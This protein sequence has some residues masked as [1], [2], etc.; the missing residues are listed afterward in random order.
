[1]KPPIH[2]RKQIPFYY[3]KT[4]AEFQKDPYERYDD[5]VIRQ[6][7]LHLA[8]ELWGGY[9]MQGIL[10][11][12]AAY[13]KVEVSASILELGCGVGRWIA[14][15]AKE[16]PTAQCWG[17]DYSYQMLK[18]AY[19]YWIGGEE[20]MLDVSNK[21]FPH[22]VQIKGEQL[23]NLQFGLAKAESL[24]FD[25]N[26]QDLVFNSFLLDRLIDPVLGLKEMHRV[27]KPGGHLIVITPLNFSQ[28]KHWQQF[29]PPIK[30]YHQ[31]TKMGFEI[32]DW[33]EEILIQEPL[34]FHSNAVSWKCLGFVASKIQR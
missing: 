24:P 25:A 10:D 7:T 21:G 15:L 22:F 3:N 28:A 9:P 12:A 26:S 32:Q 13:S 5:M 17:I 1:M 18:R 29:Y 33:N 20:L 19:E 4:E 27:L 14:T 6:T 16:N 8:D 23:K 11:F 2:T 34:D 30:I 31:L